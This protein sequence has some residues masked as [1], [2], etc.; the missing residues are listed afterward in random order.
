MLQHSPYTP[1]IL[2]S[3]VCHA[4]SW[5]I[6]HVQQSVC[7]LFQ[8]SLCPLMSLKLFNLSGACTLPHTNKI[9]AVW[10]HVIFHISA[11]N[12]KV[13]HVL[14]LTDYMFG[15]YVSHQVHPFIMFMCIVRCVKWSE[16]ALY[17][18]AGTHPP[19]TP[20]KK[21]TAAGCTHHCHM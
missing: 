21:P 15:V 19:I 16:Q 11:Y 4:S 3:H 18:H 1:P 13:H 12:W 8:R 5:Q 7:A 10:K 17:C 14:Y 6:L 9:D 20:V 2:C